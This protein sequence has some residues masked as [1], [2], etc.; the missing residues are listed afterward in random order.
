MNDW[1]CRA[2]LGFYCCVALTVAPVY[3]AVPKDVKG[4]LDLN[5][6]QAFDF[7]LKNMDGVEIDSKSLRGHWVFLHFWA[8]WCGPCRKEL[9]AIQAMI[10]SK[11]VKKVRFILVNTAETE[12]I[13]FNFFGVIGV[14]L[15]T[16]LDTTGEVTEKFKPRGLPTTIIIDPQGKMRYLFFGGRP[17]N[18]KPYQDFL[19]QLN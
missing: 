10:Q 8:S 13:V 4:F 6:K 14:D 16:L 11:H 15:P 19:N 12:D 2:F 17:W 18:T 9:P 1:F 5:K 7:K 3:G